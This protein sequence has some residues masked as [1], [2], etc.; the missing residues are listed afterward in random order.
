MIQKFLEYLEIEKRYSVNTVKSYAKD[1][2]DF[3]KFV[4]ETEAMDDIVKAQ[5]LVLRNFIVD[6]SL[7]NYSKRSLNR[8]IS[9]L[10]SFYLFLLKIRE[11][12]IDPAE[13]L[14]ALK[15]YPEKQ[16][17]MSTDEMDDLER[18]FDDKSDLL[19]ECLV[20]VL[21]QTGIRKAELCSILNKNVNFENFEITVVGKGNKER[22][23]PISENLASKLLVYFKEERKALKDSEMYLFVSKKGRKLNE[24][25]VYSV[26]NSYLS[27][28]TLK[29]KKS[30]HIL[31]H[32]FA[33][34]I[35]EN[36]AEIS[37][38]KKIMGHSS[39][40]STQVYTSANIEQ[41]KKVL[42]ASHPRASKKE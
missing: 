41:L 28:V 21:Y 38:I 10:K 40:A 15:F 6:L 19:G 16:I 23:I 11:I 29:K 37:K 26:V 13:S 14:S 18:I 27:L 35:L 34:H 20:E 22:I 24:K 36:G 2:Y 8:K 31:R 7:K 25:F 32:T 30:P 12:D 39:L 9:C 17:P 33:T 42:N 3:Q 4:L 5:K 1:L